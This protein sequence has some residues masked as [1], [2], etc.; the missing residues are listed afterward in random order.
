MLEDHIVTLYNEEATRDAMIKAFQALPKDERIKYGDAVVIFYAGH[1]SEL[2]APTTW[3]LKG[4]TQCLLSQD[5]DKDKE[6]MPI[7]DRTVGV[8]IE[9][10]AK[11]K[12]DNIVRNI[13]RSLSPFLITGH[14][15]SSSTA[16]IR[17]QVLEKTKNM[18]LALFNWRSKFL[19][20][21]ISRS[22]D[23]E[24]GSSL[25]N[26][27]STV[28]GHMSS[29]LLVA[30]KSGRTNMKGAVSLPVHFWKYLRAAL[31][32]TSPTPMSWSGSISKSTNLSVHTIKV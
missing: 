26:S 24:Q 7:P 27:R 6:I 14:R 4:A 13:P 15:L 3:R 28:S 21:S 18:F 9:D 22:G 19:K 20:P 16:V 2:P 30:R 12:G 29:W 5:Y 11:A 8:L 32:M 25:V 31:S 1:G 23:C 17:P 10:I